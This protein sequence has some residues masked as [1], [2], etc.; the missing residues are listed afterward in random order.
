MDDRWQ[1]PDLFPF[2]AGIDMGGRPVG[3]SGPIGFTQEP[4]GVC[5]LGFCS[6]GPRWHAMVGGG[7]GRQRR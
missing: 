6:L 1:E 5:T 4:R 7:I 3:G 2:D